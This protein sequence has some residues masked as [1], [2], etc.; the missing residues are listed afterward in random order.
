MFKKMLCLPVLL[1]T[2]TMI[3]AQAGYTLSGYVKDGL[4]GETLISASVSVKGETRGVSSNQ[5]GFYS[6]TLPKGKYVVIASFV[7]YEPLAI[8]VDLNKSEQ[9]NFDLSPQATTS[10]EIVISS[11]KRDANVKTAQM[12]KIDLSINTIKSIPVLFGEVDVLKT[13]QLIPGVRNAG[14]GNSGIYVRGG[15]PDQ[16]LIMLDDAVVYNPGHLFG[17]FSIFNGDAIKN[18]TLIKGGMPAQ[19]GG[20]L[21]SV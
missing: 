10:Q 16:N 7:G 14:E 6:I 2:A 5:Y 3:Q 17:F 12:G 9:H 21:S 1:C 8:E 4:S 20:R 15:G 13:L 19:Y 18:L 11:R